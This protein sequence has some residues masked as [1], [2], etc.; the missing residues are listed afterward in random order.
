LTGSLEVVTS[1]GGQLAEGPVWDERSG[2]L[3]WV[4]IPGATVHRW[5]ASSGARG[6]W[7][8]GANAGCVI[9][10]EQDGGLVALPGGIKTLDFETGDLTD[11]AAIPE[12]DG[13]RCNDGKCDATGRLWVGTMHASDEPVGALYRVDEGE[14]AVMREQVSCSNG[15]GWSPDGATMYWVDS[16]TETIFAFD[17]D[18]DDGTITNERTFVHDQR[19]LPDGLAVDLDGCVWCARWDGWCVTR[20]CPDGTVDRTIEFPVA[21]PTS[22]AFEGGNSDVIYVTSASYGLT[23]EQRAHQP[24]AGAVF[25]VEAGIAGVPVARCAT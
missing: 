10:R 20:Y 21:R 8:V 5:E 19:G 9:L 25:R 11:Y 6:S 13:I 22:L 17:F 23:D 1:D 16:P 7:N 3:F 14:A 2:S 12:G 18:A 15:I 4:D 24:L